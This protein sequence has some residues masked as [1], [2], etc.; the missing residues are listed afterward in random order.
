[1]PGRADS[2]VME[3][4]SSIEKG[5]LVRTTLV[6]GFYRVVRVL[7][8]TTQIRCSGG[9]TYVVATATLSTVRPAPTAV[10]S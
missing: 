4:K 7:G 9:P 8:E 3:T 5:S 2:L 1:M 6:G 10:L